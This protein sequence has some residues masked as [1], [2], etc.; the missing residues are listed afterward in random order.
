M[1]TFGKLK[2][3]IGLK[4]DTATTIG[5]YSN[6]VPNDK[7]YPCVV[8]KFPDCTPEETK[9][10]WTLELDFWDKEADNDVDST[11]VLTAVEAVKAVLNRSWQVETGGCFK[12]YLDFA[13][14]ILDDTVGVYRFNQRYEITMY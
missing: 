14:E 11:D 6:K 7:S 12:S 1:L 8:M 13:G 3:F 4:I 2:E 5:V 10:V 9:E